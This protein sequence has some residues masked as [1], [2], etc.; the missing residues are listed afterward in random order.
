MFAL[1]VVAHPSPSSFSHAMAHTARA[2]LAERGFELAF[3]DL[4]AER[5]DPVQPTG[6]LQN[7]ASSDA[8]VEQHCAELVRAG[9]VLV[10]HPNWWGSPPAILK[11]WIDRVFRLGTAYGYPPG[12]PPEGE[13]QGLLKARRALVF[14]TSNTPPEREQAVF[15]D[16]LESLWKRCVFP[17]CGVNDVVRRMVGPMSGSSEGDRTRWLGEVRA[18]AEEAALA[19][20]Q[21]RP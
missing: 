4:Y 7:T 20:G 15:G 6:E 5:F 21:G 8:L 10:F 18:L 14:N 19:A 1:L 17:L 3:H 11:G 12:V 13:P 9:L 16:P 2:V